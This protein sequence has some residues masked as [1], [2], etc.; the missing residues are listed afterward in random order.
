[1]ARNSATLILLYVIISLALIGLLGW[2][3]FSKIKKKITVTLVLFSLGSVLLLLS[4]V[5]F[6]MSTNSNMFMWSIYTAILGSC[7]L[8]GSL[9]YT[10]SKGLFETQK[11]LKTY[12]YIGSI[13]IIIGLSIVSSMG[14]N[15]FTGNKKLN[16]KTIDKTD[17][18]DK[19]DGQESS[20][21]D[22][23]SSLEMT[24]KQ[25]DEKL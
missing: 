21:P 3:L 8:L 13:V 17:K 1:M 9:I 7:L 11:S 5:L 19:I 23:S 25:S 14:I 12:G 15:N 2:I 22:D 18:T 20:L 24:E 10:D 6:G 4:D 16:S